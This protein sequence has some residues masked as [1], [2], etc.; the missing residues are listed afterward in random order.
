MVKTMGIYT[1]RIELLL[2]SDHYFTII[3]FRVV[4]QGG[5]V[6]NWLG[7]RGNIP[8]TVPCLKSVLFSTIYST[9]DECLWRMHSFVRETPELSC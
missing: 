3:A 2:L 7:G 1:F 6:L 9:A 8:L 4:W 5:N